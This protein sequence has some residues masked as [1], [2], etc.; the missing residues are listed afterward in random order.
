MLPIYR[1]N[2][3]LQAGFFDFG[4]IGATK[5]TDVIAQVY[6]PDRDVGYCLHLT[7]KFSDNK[8]IE[9]T[10]WTPK[11]HVTRSGSDFMGRAKICG[12]ERY[13]LGENTA[14]ELVV[15]RFDR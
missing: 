7:D 8:T 14:R 2:C 12:C 15:Y 10:T 6:E 13:L 4:N 5:W 3:N 11:S 9:L 1:G